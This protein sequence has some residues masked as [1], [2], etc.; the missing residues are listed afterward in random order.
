MNPLRSPAHG[1]GP[2]GA[3]RTTVAAL[4]AASVC[5]LAASVPGRPSPRS[6]DPCAFDAAGTQI[7]SNEQYALCFGGPPDRRPEDPAAPPHA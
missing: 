7:L 6:G 1:A 2:R 3:R 4:V 5:L